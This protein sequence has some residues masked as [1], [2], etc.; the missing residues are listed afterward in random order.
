[1]NNNDIL[2]RLRYALNLSDAKMIEIFARVGQVLNEAEVHS[3]LGKEDE[4]GTVIC[5]DDLMAA[6]LDSLIVELRGP[7]RPGSPPPAIPDRISNNDII[8]KVRIALKLQESDMMA[9]LEAGGQP[10]SKGELSALFRKPGHKHYRACGDQVMRAFLRGLT[11]R[12]RPSK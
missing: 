9:I 8:K 11:L 6:F 1:M 7:P 10:M 2:R 4:E 5:L 3:L 12:L